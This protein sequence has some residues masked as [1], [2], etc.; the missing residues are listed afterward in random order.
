[1][2]PLRI[3]D[4]VEIV[5]RIRLRLHALFTHGHEEI[6]LTQRV[7]KEVSDDGCPMLAVNEIAL[8]HGD[9]VCIRLRV[10]NN[11][12]IGIQFFHIRADR[13]LDVLGVRRVQDPVSFPNWN[14]NQFFRRHFQEF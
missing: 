4:G 12:V 11:T 9:T 8:D 13:S 5:H 10:L 14:G 7:P 2:L 1:M 3:I 6:R